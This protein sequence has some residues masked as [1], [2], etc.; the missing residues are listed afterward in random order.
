VTTT[1]KAPSSVAEAP[2][3]DISL[4]VAARVDLLLSAMTLEEKVGQLG[5]RWVGNDPAD[6]HG[7]AQEATGENAGGDAGPEGL[8]GR[9][10]DDVLNVAPMQDVF[11]AAGSVPLAEAARHG[12]G[13]LTRVYGSR[14]VSP[15]EGAAELVRQQHVVINGSRLGVPAIV[16]E[17]CLTGFTTFGATVYPAAIAWG[18]TFD[19]ELVHRMAAAIGADMAAL[20]VHQ[21][22]S[23]VLDVVRDYRWGRVEETMGEDPYL[24]SALGAAYVRGLQSAGVIATL[25]HFAG[26]S[27]SRGARNHGPVPMGRRELLDVVLPP[28]EAAVRQ[29]GAGSVMNSYAD[30]DGVPAV[31]DAWLLTDL[32]R[33]AWRF[34]GTVVS[35]YWAVPFL[36]SM[37]RVAAD[38]ADAGAQALA[39]GLDV[40]LPDTIGFGPGLVE[41]V[42]R[43]VV[44]EALVDRAA[45]RVLTQKAG[46]ALLDPGWTPEASVA[47][48]A[49]RDLDPASHRAL[50][51]EMAERSVVLLDAGTALPL[52]G[53][54]RPPLRRV[55]VVGPCAD[56]PLTFMGCYAFPNH[57]L[58]RYPGLGLGV[59]VPT[60]LDA[61]R[62]ELPGVEVVHERGCDV[63]DPDTS[64]FAPAVEAARGSDVC[65]VL[66]G[67]RAG[68][69]GHG[70]SGEGCDA[71]DLRLPG[72][73]GDLVAALL[74]T[75]TPLVVVVVSGRPYAL[76]D[77]SGRAAGLVQ[78]F[79]PGEEGG[80]AIASVLSG[81]VQPAGRLPVQIPRHPGGQPGTYLQ[82]PLGAADTGTS[83]L[84]P[85][86]L[87]PFGFGRSYTA[88]E[89]EGPDVAF[90]ELATDG[91]VTVGVRVRNTGARAGSEVVQLYLRDE[92]ASVTRPVRQLAGFA[93]VQ[94][95]PG[96]AADVRFRLH[97]DLTA[98][99]GRDLRRVVEPGDVEVLIGTSAE[100][101][102]A[103]ARVR[104]TGQVRHLDGERR[105]TTPVE[106]TPAPAIADM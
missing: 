80:G 89:I 43:G 15:V 31:A 20:G 39:A 21:G 58:P 42:R 61:L 34:D 69:F 59:E 26:Y 85:A 98:F 62:A 103:R 81:R 95:E 102:P 17:E 3:R 10:A 96:A 49:E 79:M 44:P 9:P 92:V 50:A 35:D 52:L 32:L 71:E 12:L 60:A 55:A 41:R 25:K 88:F 24:V 94:L 30:V 97:A 72:V 77:V 70:T 2:W 38:D 93:R 74:A 51:R 65:V 28:F 8:E 90:A 27:A 13:H 18:A 66:V 54:G 75:G 105:M 86:P 37:H 91:E 48:A 63:R 45:R 99:T 7:G 46:L 11:A 22:L 6:D 1:D 5:S 83:N 4:P 106:V 16:H 19:P 101:L 47:A 40:E 78:A 82:P 29:A 36:A 14:P 76:G 67:D 73:Q 100:D 33:D 64:G 56:D 84:D 57:V 68:L 87:F 104:L 53:E 23:P